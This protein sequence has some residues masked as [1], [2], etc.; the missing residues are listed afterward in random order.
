MD[1]F[2][3]N[4]KRKG[5]SHLLLWCG[6]DDL[7]PDRVLSADGCYASFQSLTEIVDFTARSGIE[8]KLTTPAILFD[9][10]LVGNWIIDKGRFPPKE[11]LDTWNLFDDFC[12]ETPEWIAYHDLSERHSDCHCELSKY[13]LSA[14][15]PGFDNDGLVGE[16][17]LHQIK[18]TLR[19]G[20]T[21]FDTTFL[22]VH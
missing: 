14:D 17:S 10:D 21:A 19:Q 12:I 6:N 1:Y 16:S 22:E 13:V 2:P 11:A 8:L 9:L 7:S 5:R 18:E 20:L 4:L 15:L 3:I